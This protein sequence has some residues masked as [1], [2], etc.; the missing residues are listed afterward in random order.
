[1]TWLTD[2][3]GMG[4]MGVHWA[5]T[6]LVGD[7]KIAADR[8]EALV[9]APGK[10]GT[11]TLAAVEYVVIKADWDKAHH[12]APELYGHTFNVTAAPNRY[13]LPAFYSLHVWVWK[14]NPAGTFEMFNPKVSCP[15]V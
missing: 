2:M 1:M 6:A 7:G 15:P 12:H 4:A 11:L 13:G 14:S 9:Y 3:P 5:N 8:P 10:D